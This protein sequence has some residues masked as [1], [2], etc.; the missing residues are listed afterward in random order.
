[1]KPVDQ[2]KILNTM[3]EFAHDGILLLDPSGIIISANPAA[4]SI[5]GFKSENDILQPQRKFTDFFNFY[6]FNDTEVPLEQ[7]PF[8]RA[9]N[10]ERITDYK[11][12][13]ISK[14]TGKAWYGIISAIP[15][16][17]DTKGIAGVVVSIKD[18]SDSKV[19]I[20]ECEIG[21]EYYRSIMSYVA[22][23]VIV[24]DPDGTIL[25]M[26]PAAMRMYGFESLN[27]AVRNIYEY[28]ET[29]I[30]YDSEG[31]SF[32]VEKWP[33]SRA[34]RG[35]LFSNI[36]VKISRKKTGTSWIAKII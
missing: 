34:L 11:G 20:K 27:K 25:D 9:L 32:P 16:L 14:E 35:E 33:I 19:E 15:M 36:E 13:G 6:D 30:V 31:N 3:I 23:G 1:M 18:I 21:K 26:N 2:Q 12:K 28:R 17:D 4:S 8:S 29:F 24:A 5:F 7:L 10:G 22:E